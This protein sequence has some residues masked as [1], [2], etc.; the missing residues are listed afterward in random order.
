MKRLLIAALLALCVSAEAHAAEHYFRYSVAG[1]HGSQ[2]WSETEPAE[3]DDDEDEEEEGPISIGSTKFP[4]LSAAIAAATSGDVIS[5]DGGYSSS[6][7]GSILVGVDGLTI[8]GCTSDGTRLALAP[9]MSSLSAPDCSGLWNGNDGANVFNGGDG[10]YIVNAG[11]GDDIINIGAVPSFGVGIINGGAGADT[12]RVAGGAVVIGFDSQDRLD[13]RGFP[14]AAT[15]V[16]AVIGVPGPLWNI[17]LPG[18][19]A[20][21]RMGDDDHSVL[22]LSNFI[23]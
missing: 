13:L 6:A 18:L 5:I 3:A 23:L 12:Y 9:G 15:A 10:Q 19:T 14:G 8:R 22:T 21:L 11:D 7:E 2:V 4:T 17:T 20:S 16:A 1:L